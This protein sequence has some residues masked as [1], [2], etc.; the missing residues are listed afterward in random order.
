MPSASLHLTKKQKIIFWVMV[1]V[2]ALFSS[3]TS[4]SFDTFEAFIRL[5]GRII[6]GVVLFALVPTFLTMM[7]ELITL[8]KL[9]QKYYGT[10]FIAISV[11]V[12]SLIVMGATIAA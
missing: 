11:L 6:V 7:I 12:A 3:Q 8:R 1:V 4:Y 2:S 5:L 10:I 9:P